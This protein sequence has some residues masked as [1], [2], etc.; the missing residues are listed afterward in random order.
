MERTLN[1]PADDDEVKP[2]EV[3]ISQMPSL[4]A[5]LIMACYFLQGFYSHHALL[6]L[7]QPID[8]SLEPHMP[9]LQ[10]VY[11]KRGMQLGG[12]LRL[13]VPSA[14]FSAGGRK[15]RKRPD[16]EPGID[17]GS[18]RPFGEEHSKIGCRIC[19]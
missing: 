5:L 8:K 7:H 10:V 6:L 19:K 2:I 4:R 11:Q 9:A 15:R 12:L 17:G 3:C 13:G 16:T 14:S 18:K 1:R